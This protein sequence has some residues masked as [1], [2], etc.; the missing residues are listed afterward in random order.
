MNAKLC[1]VL[2][3]A[4]MFTVYS[5]CMFGIKYSNKILARHESI[6]NFP[7]PIKKHVEPPKVKKVV[8]IAQKVET[9]RI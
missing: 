2:F 8:T 3:I 6:M 1:D 9:T 5:V 7:I 4:Y